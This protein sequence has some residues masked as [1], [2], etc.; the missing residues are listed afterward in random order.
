MRDSEGGSC[1]ALGGGGTPEHL[2]CGAAR[3]LQS[4]AIG[5][6]RP[7]VRPPGN[8]DSPLTSSVTWQGPETLSLSFLTSQVFMT[9]WSVSSGGRVDGLSTCLV[10]SAVPGVRGTVGSKNGPWIRRTDV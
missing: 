6:P 10:S 9:L 3:L 1:Q 4:N 8:L 5:L 7:S 2:P